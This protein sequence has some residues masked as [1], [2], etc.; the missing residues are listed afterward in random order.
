M[1]DLTTIVAGADWES[2][3]DYGHNTDGTP[4][5]AAW[6]EGLADAL[7]WECESSLCNG[8]ETDD[9]GEPAYHGWPK[10]GRLERRDHVV[11]AHVECGHCGVETTYSV[12]TQNSGGYLMV[13][14]EDSDYCHLCESWGNV[15]DAEKHRAFNEEDRS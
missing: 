2:R 3:P 9:L 6:P 13:A 12:S 14:V 7:V 8:P 5:E 1:A 11:T 10:W 15:H 4:V